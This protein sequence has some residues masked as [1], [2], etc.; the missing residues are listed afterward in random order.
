MNRNLPYPAL[1][2]E[3]I[4]DAQLNEV[5]RQQVGG[6]DEVEEILPKRAL[7]EAASAV[8]ERDRN[9]RRQREAEVVEDKDGED[10]QQLVIAQPVEQENENIA[11]HAVVRFEKDRDRAKPEQTEQGEQRLFTEAGEGAQPEIA[12]QQGEEH[13][14][15]SYQGVPVCT[16][17]KGT[18]EITASAARL[19]P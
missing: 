18:S 15:F 1:L 4:A 3:L 11:M 7:D 16:R 17:L 14:L 10:A 8:V 19:I 13:V 6:V 9:E 12:K 5:D 2:L